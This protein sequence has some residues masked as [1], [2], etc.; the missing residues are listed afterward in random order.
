MQWHTGKKTTLSCIKLN[1]ATLQPSIEYFISIKVYDVSIK[2]IS[3][4]NN[5]VEKD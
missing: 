2:K 3:N 4:Y 5:L 1:N